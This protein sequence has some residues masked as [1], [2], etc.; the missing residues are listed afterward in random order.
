MELTVKII[1]WEISTIF[2]FGLGNLNNI[3]IWTDWSSCIK[4]FKI[5]FDT[6]KHITRVNAHSWKYYQF[7]NLHVCVTDPLPRDKLCAKLYYQTKQKRRCRQWM[8]L[9]LFHIVTVFIIIRMP[10]HYNISRGRRNVARPT[11]IGIIILSLV[12]SHFR[13]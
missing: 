13:V 10:S 9:K 7:Y 2:L 5:Y 1:K 11:R 12:C 3:F 4:I 6:N 8:K